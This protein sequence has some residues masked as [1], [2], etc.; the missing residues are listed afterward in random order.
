MQV[1]HRCGDLRGDLV[2]HCPQSKD[3]L[4]IG[5]SLCASSTAVTRA[6]ACDAHPDLTLL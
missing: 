4:Y 5:A 3:S 1:L 2:T 6:A